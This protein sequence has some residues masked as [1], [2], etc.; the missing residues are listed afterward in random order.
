MKQDDQFTDPLL[1][2]TESINY[3]FFS[4]GPGGLGITLYRPLNEEGLEI[5]K[6]FHKVFSLAY[7]RFRDIEK[8]ETQAR[9]AE[10]ELALERVRAR[11]MAMQNSDELA[12]V[13][14]LL[15]QQM[16]ELGISTYSSG[17]TIWDEDRDK[18]ISWVCNADGS[19][20]PPFYMPM[21]EE[22]WHREQYESWK[23][24]ED[25][26]VKDLAGED[27]KAYFRYLRSFPL[28]DKAFA[29]SEA[30]GHP[31]PVRQV[32][33][34]ANFSHGNLLFI[35]LEPRPEAHEL[36]KRFVKVFEQTYT[37]FLDLQK[38][39]AQAREAKIETA[40]EKIRS[41]TMAMQK[42]EELQEVAVL[43]YKEL[44]ALGVTNFVTCGYVEVNEDIR[45]Q[46]T[47]VTAP[48][49]DTMGL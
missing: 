47:W 11:T 26:I 4:I 6:R 36:F 2:E 21:T 20:N 29:T 38:A 22:S 31:I 33:H 8:A 9:E 24:G 28:L 19:L 40:L 35:T 15:F 37:R 3:H 34:A 48:G 17:F 43:L 5:F 1:D 44:I 41:R 46:H 13:S 30:A 49:G 32:H 25:F 23:K 39:E 27:W 12:E 42:G 7:R 45:R 18:L 10:I 14:S 16:K